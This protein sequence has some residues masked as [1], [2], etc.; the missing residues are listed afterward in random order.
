[1]AKWTGEVSV[2]PKGKSY[3]LQPPTFVTVDA[4]SMPV[5]IAKAG[6]VGLARIKA[7]RGRLSAE[8]VLVKV[9]RV[10]ESKPRPAT[11]DIYERNALYTDR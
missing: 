9:V 8:Q 10:K 5:A 2:M 1:M 7:L 6:R 4:G 11:A 3:Y